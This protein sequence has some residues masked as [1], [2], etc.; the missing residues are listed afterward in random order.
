MIYDNPV[1]HGDMKFGLTLL[2]KIGDGNVSVSPISI[3]TALA[4]LYEGARGETARQIAQATGLPEN[5]AIRLEAFHDVMSGLN[6]AQ[7]QY[8]LKFANGIWVDGKAVIIPGYKNKL[9]ANF[10]ADIKG[11]DFRANP[12][13]ERDDINKWVAGITEEKIPELFPAGSISSQ[14]IMA[15][16]NAL[17]FKA[18]WQEQ[19]NPSLTQKQDFTLPDGQMAKVDMMRKGAVERGYRLPEFRYAE[20]DGVQLVEIPY[21]NGHLVKLA[22]LPPKGT[23]LKNLEES[24]IREGFCFAD[25]MGEANSEKFA[26]LE[27]PRHEINGSYG[28]VELLQQMGIKDMFSQVTADFSGMTPADVFVSSAIHKT[29]FKTD[30]EG[31]EGAA[32]TGMVVTLKGITVPS[33]PKVFVANR[34]YLEMVVSPLTG[35]VLFLNRVE[36]PRA[37]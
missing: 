35:A 27:I 23:S 3:R 17:Y 12:D 32:A 21:V 37:K 9:T 14:T 29:F 25:F 13:G 8:T 24:L 20:M 11:A 7:R 28:L 26:Q 22:M 5:E 4:M 31:S 6:T 36:D 1:T 30:E 18:K 15:L 34:P 16:A 2:S 19:F 33:K 10:L